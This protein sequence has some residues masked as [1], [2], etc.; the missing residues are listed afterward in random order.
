MVPLS[1]KAAVFIV[2]PVKGIR[3]YVLTINLQ[4]KASSSP[5]LVQHLLSTLYPN[6]NS[7][8]LI[9]Y[10]LVSIDLLCNKLIGSGGMASNRVIQFKFRYKFQMSKSV[11]FE[12]W[13]QNCI[14]D[15]NFDLFSIIFLLKSNKIFHFQLNFD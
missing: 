5:I 3:A 6:E 11:C 15:Y 8:A 12:I 14:V 1:N 13:L 9:M 2:F 4:D 10:H 7:V